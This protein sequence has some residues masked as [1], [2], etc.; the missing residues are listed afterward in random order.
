MTTFDD[1]EQAFE[2]MFVH[3]QEMRFRA[4]A[5]RDRL[6]GLWAAELMGMTGEEAAEYARSIVVED[7]KEAGEEDV[8]RKVHADLAAAGHAD[9]PLREKMAELLLTA[10]AQVQGEAEQG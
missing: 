7:L 4:Q 2:G 8:F 6:L 1:R 5:R 9:A 10:Q 3:D